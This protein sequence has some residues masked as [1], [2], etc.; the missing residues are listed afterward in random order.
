MQLAFK[1]CPK[2]GFEIEVCMSG[3]FIEVGTRSVHLSL[4]RPRWTF[5]NTTYRTSNGTLTG[6]LFVLG[7][8]VSY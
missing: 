2:I 3:L 1:L 5:Q 6:E 8:A 4:E 7:L